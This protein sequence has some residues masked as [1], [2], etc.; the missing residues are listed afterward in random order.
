MFPAFVNEKLEDC[1]KFI[2]S[3]WVDTSLIRDTDL[4]LTAF[5]HKSYAADYRD[6]VPHNERLE[7]VGD[8]I[9]GAVINTA[10]YNS[11]P[12]ESESTL[13]LYKIAL[14][15]AEML[16]EVAK[17]IGLDQV[18]FLGNGELKNDGRNKTTILCDCLEG[19]LG[20]ISLDLGA[21]AVENV[22]KKHIY[23]KIE[24]IQKWQVKSNKTLL[25]EEVQ[26]HHKTTPVYIDE[27]HE[28]D[29]KENVLTY[30]SRVI[31]DGQEIA[32]GYGTNKKKA[33]DEAAGI[34]YEKIKI[35]DEKKEVL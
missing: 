35:I 11:F 34:A 9:L 5:V 16:A 28:Q 10:L 2:G 23:S 7:F 31:V 3:L 1:K 12:E 13:T 8:A 6:S 22:I 30:S 24:L 27:I 26:K 29:T 25:Q 20:Y 19:L 21:N 4:L 14:V 32:V 15:R 18:I 17:D 33:Q